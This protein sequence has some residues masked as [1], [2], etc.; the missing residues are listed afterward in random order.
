MRRENLTERRREVLEFIWNKS[1]YPRF[2]IVTSCIVA[3]ASE[4][5]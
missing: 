3:G 5:W 4:I 2:L 1:E